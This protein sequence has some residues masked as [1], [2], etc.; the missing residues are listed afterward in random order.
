METAPFYLGSRSL[1]SLQTCTWDG[2][3]I[4]QEAIKEIDFT[5]ICGHREEKE[6]M[7]AYYSGASKLAWPDSRHN[8]FP[9]EAFD[10]IPCLF[11]N[12]KDTERFKAVV[13]VI[14]TAADRLGI[15]ITTGAL[16]WGWDFG[17]VEIKRR[18]R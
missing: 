5:V 11:T 18:K 9:S 10:F 14:K 13:R 7:L 3:R 1:L 17:H 2:Q 16:D 4:A 6:Q 8:S 15:E 12:W